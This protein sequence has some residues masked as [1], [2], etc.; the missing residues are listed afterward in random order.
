[1][2]TCGWGKRLAEKGG[3]QGREKEYGSMLAG[4]KRKA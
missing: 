3:A 1:M 2:K 4:G